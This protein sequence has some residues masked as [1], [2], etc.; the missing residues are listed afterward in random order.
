MGLTPPGILAR[1][2]EMM[3]ANDCRYPFSIDV[4]SP[5]IRFHDN[6]IEGSLRFPGTGKKGIPISAASDDGGAKE[7][8]TKKKTRRSKTKKDDE[9]DV[10]VEGRADDV[11][12]A[13][14][15]KRKTAAEDIIVGPVATKPVSDG[16]AEGGGDDNTIKV[17]GETSPSSG[18]LDEAE[19]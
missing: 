1:S 19:L 10:Y 17:A 6:H 16:M 4:A 7:E 9:V 14:A 11:K 3:E 5:T 18:D 8:A 13:S 2:K 12:G 15:K